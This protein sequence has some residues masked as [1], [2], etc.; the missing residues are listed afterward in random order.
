MNFFWSKDH[1]SHVDKLLFTKHLSVMLKSGI[2]LAEAIALLSS[3]AA[4]PGFKQ[5]LTAIQKDIDN[6]K[7]LYDAL[8]A[9]PTAFDP[10]Y[11]RLVNIGEESGTLQRNL[12]YLAVQHSPYQQK[13]CSLLQKR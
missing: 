5:L 6:G 1:I 13:F 3:Q 4:N 9:H 7:T 11:L 12:D 10:L 8:A 2:T